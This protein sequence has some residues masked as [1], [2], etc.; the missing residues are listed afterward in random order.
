MSVKAA[1][2]VEF[3]LS[4]P[5][6][7]IGAGACGLTAA[8]AARDAGADVLVFERDASPSGSTA[9]S[10]GMIPA[11]GTKVQAARGIDDSGALFAADIQRKAHGENDPAMDTERSVGGLARPIAHPV[12]V[13]SG[14]CSSTVGRYST[15]W[16]LPSNVRLSIIFKATSG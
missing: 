12:V 11:A 15:S 14:G 16:I 9:L 8:L 2:G 1:A 6:A 7:V 3:P 10:S 13:P 4:V 5:L